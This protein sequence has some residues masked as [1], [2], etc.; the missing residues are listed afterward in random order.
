MVHS[1]NRK[2]EVFDRNRHPANM[3][4]E[5]MRT[6]LT[7][8]QATAT[9]GASTQAKM[10]DLGISM[11]QLTA[12]EFCFMGCSYLDGMLRDVKAVIKAVNKAHKNYSIQTNK[13]LWKSCYMV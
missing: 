2:N 5:S 9:F 6:V 1:K 12:T 8:D 11:M 4:I 13:E 10:K 3:R 7:A